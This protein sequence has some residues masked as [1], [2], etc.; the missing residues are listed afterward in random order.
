MTEEELVSLRRQ[1]ATARF[2]ERV[3]RALREHGAE[4]ELVSGWERG[5]E[6]LAAR[7]EAR[8]RELGAH[9]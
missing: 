8:E 2:A 6:E 4:E 3:A 1:K 5:A 7:A 9:P